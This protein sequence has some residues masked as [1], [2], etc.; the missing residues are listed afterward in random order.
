MPGET[1]ITMVLRAVFCHAIHLMR[2]NPSMRTTP[3]LMIPDR[4]V[5]T[6]RRTHDT[7]FSDSRR[8]KAYGRGCL[9]SL[10]VFSGWTSRTKQC[11][12]LR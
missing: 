7:V 4:V 6:A 11:R 9:G 8:G 1:D 3:V 5:W 10:G 12:P 2:G